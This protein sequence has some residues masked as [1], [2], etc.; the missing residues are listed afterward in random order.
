MFESESGGGTGAKNIFTFIITFPDLLPPFHQY[1]MLFNSHPA[2]LLRES[3]LFCMP[4]YLV[5]R[6]TI[7]MMSYASKPFKS[8]QTFIL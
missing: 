4:F 3:M 1:R 5:T 2:T 6:V 7:I 8:L